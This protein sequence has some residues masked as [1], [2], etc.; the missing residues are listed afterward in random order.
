[1]AEDPSSAAQ[2]EVAVLEPGSA[3][4]SVGAQ[5]GGD[6]KDKWVLEPLTSE[7]EDRLVELS[8]LALS[9][10]SHKFKT[11]YRREEVR[12]RARKRGRMCGPE[13]GFNEKLYQC[14]VHEKDASDIYPSM[15]PQQGSVEPCSAAAPVVRPHADPS[16]PCR[17]R[18][19]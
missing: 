10:S 14:H 15:I 19:E 12:L 18:C 8:G 1:M 11:G 16:W 9:M 6:E 17:E 4:E 5:V 3:G 13:D 2:A 7:E